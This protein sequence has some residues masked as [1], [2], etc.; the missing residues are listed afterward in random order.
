MGKRL[1]EEITE[2][3]YGNFD[4][5]EVEVLKEYLS[6]DIQE[7][8]YPDKES[9]RP[10]IT[11]VN[12][13]EINERWQLLHRTWEQKTQKVYNDQLDVSA[14]SNI[15]GCRFLEGERFHQMV[16][17][18]SEVLEVLKGIKNGVYTPHDHTLALLRMFHVQY[19]P[20][21][22]F[23][24]EIKSRQGYNH[25]IGSIID[26]IIKNYSEALLEMAV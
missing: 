21:K 15:T 13:E 4:K 3:R 26:A 19:L 8:R 1:L 9:T 20:L 7:Y 14:F 17:N 5:Q 12:W 22:E 10:V 24:Q 16:Q 6:N 25:W 23:P 18:P 11:Y 2:N